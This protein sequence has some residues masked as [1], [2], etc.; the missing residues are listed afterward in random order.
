MNTYTQDTGIYP[1]TLT[2]YKDDNN[3]ELRTTIKDR[4]K[5]VTGMIL[6]ELDSDTWAVVDL[7]NIEEI[8]LIIK[9]VNS[10]EDTE[11]PVMG[12]VVEATSTNNATFTFTENILKQL[13]GKYTAAVKITFPNGTI[14]TLNNYINFTVLPPF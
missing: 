8:K 14:I 6:D 7:S 11:N 9:S 1:N 12:K 10:S 2:M 4:N 13:E 5:A 3:I